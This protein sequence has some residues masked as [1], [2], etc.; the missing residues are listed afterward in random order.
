[1]RLMR[2]GIY[3][4][5]SSIWLSQKRLGLPVTG[6]IDSGIAALVKMA[7]IAEFLWQIKKATQPGAA[8]AI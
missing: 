3:V 2:L 5:S 7:K 4:C 8:K 1:M 6:F